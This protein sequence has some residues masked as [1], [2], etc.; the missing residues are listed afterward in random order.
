MFTKALVWTGVFAIATFSTSTANAD[1]FQHKHRL[2]RDIVLLQ[3]HVRVFHHSVRHQDCYYRID[4]ES[5]QL[6]DDVDHFRR[7]AIRGGSQWHLRSD[8]QS[9]AREMEDI[10]RLLRHVRDYRVKRNWVE[11]E[12]AFDRV[13]FDLYERHCGFIRNHCSVSKPVIDHGHGHRHGRPDFGRDRR[14]GPD[15]RPDTDRDRDRG[16]DHGHAFQPGQRPDSNRGR[17]EINL[18][19]RAPAWAH[20]LKEFTK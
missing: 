12:R 8:F 16:R 6:L 3:H 17:V 11:V 18:K 4:V 19:N 7:T 1:Y 14:P 2:I 10:Q 9:I 5:H 20:L 13:Y 15:R